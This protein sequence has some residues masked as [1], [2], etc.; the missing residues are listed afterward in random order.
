MGGQLIGWALRSFWNEQP[1][2]L[3][4]HL[5]P[6]HKQPAPL[7]VASRPHTIALELG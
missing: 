5:S 6:V 3:S 4:A 1:L 2:P 7:F